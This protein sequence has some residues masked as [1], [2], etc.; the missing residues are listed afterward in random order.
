MLFC[1]LLSIC[2]FCGHAW[3]M[4]RFPG[5]GSNLG[6][7]SDL[8]HCSDNAKSLTR[9]ATGEP[10]VLLFKLIY[11]G[12]HSMLAHF[13]IFYFFFFFFFFLLFR[14]AR[15]TYGCSH[16][17]YHIRAIAA[18]LHHSSRQRRIPNPLSEA[19]DRTHN[20]MVPSRIR[21]RCTTMGT[22]YVSL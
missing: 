22:R 18:D 21:F 15:T 19:R 13:L 3:G 17:L 10:R 11:P 5:Q 1:I 20:L 6:H 12:N 14:A 16:M 2:L 4:W 7:S 8:S 9:G